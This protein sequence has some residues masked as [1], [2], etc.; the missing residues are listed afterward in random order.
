MNLHVYMVHDK[1]GKKY[2]GKLVLMS[3]DKLHGAM[4][5]V[6]ADVQYE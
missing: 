2:K 5:S 6:L 3:H 4:V 1:Y